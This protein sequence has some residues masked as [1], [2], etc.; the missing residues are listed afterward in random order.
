MYYDQLRTGL[1]YWKGSAN[2]QVLIARLLLRGRC[3]FDDKFWN[4]YSVS[5]IVK[6]ALNEMLEALMRNANIMYAQ[7]VTI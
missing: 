5:K 7:L 6:Q 1:T 3:V 2:D 4:N